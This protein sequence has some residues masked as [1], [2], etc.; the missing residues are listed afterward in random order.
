MMRA[1]Y[2]ISEY[3]PNEG[4]QILDLRHVTKDPIEAVYRAGSS[5]TSV[6]NSW[7]VINVAIDRLIN[8]PMGFGNDSQYIDPFAQTVRDYIE[9]SCVRFEGSVLGN[10]FRDW[11]PKNAAEI[12][13][14][15]CNEAN[16]ALLKAPPSGA[17]W[18]WDFDS[19]ERRVQQNNVQ[20]DGWQHCGPISQD[21]GQMEFGRYQRVVDLI[22]KNGYQRSIELIDGDIAGQ[23]LSKGADWRTMI[24]DG[25]HRFAALQA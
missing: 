13:G 2:R 19:T 12:L 15:D 16:E 25:M 9:R 24:C 21:K 8:D 6:Q 14:L 22:I 1:G 11:Q 23:I 3:R 4:K 20:E 17:V 18:P 10:Y 5:Q 7:V